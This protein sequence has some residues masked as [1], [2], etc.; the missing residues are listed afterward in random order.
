MAK[1]KVIVK[2]LIS[3]EDLGNMDVLCTDKTGTLTKG[4]LLF[5]EAQDL[6]GNS[7]QEVMLNALLTNDEFTSKGGR[8]TSSSIDQALWR[9]E[10]GEK[11]K[12]NLPK[13]TLIDK[14]EFSFENKRA[15]VLVTDG[16][17]RF[18]VSKGSIESILSICSNAFIRGRKQ[19]LDDKLRIGLRKRFE[20]YENFGYKVIAV[21]KKDEL[22]GNSIKE[23]DLTL[24]GIIL[25]EDP[26]KETA[27]DSI[28]QLISSGVRIV[29]LSGDDSKVVEKIAIE[30]GMDFGNIRV[31]SGE[32][33]EKMDENQFRDCVINCN[34]FSRLTPEEKY[35][36]VGVL[37]K[38]G[39]VVGFLGDG[40][41]DSPALKAADVGIAVDSGAVIAKEA[42]DIVLLSKDLNV[43]IDG[44]KLGRTTFA[45]I[46]KYILN[47]ISANFGNMS[48]VALSSIFLKFI[49][50]LPSQILLNNLIS[51]IPLLAIVSDSVDKNLLT[52]PKHWDIRL[53]G[54]FMIY[55][56]ILSSIFDMMLIL[57]MIIL[58]KVD[59]VVFR[60]AWFIESSISEIIITFSIRTKLIFFKSRPSLILL[61][62]SIFSILL[63]LVLP[64][65][66]LGKNFF[67][68]VPLPKQVWM[69]II[70]DLALY[71]VSCEIIKKE[72]F[73][74]FSN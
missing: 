3:V 49:P 73:K 63:V 24:L 42:A 2:K 28:A 31:V 23:I 36:I 1:K 32:D 55:F 68:F 17:H 59:P 27:K 51:D 56:G 21:A 71:F 44:I 34:L 41:N 64:F 37:N 65:I 7:S 61:I 10:L 46:T 33:L 19:K 45:N 22:L 26:I 35:K 4:E 39:K 74:R 57:G 6:D 50:L 53:I 54:K 58:L 48:T 40:I 16:N 14:N 66:G 18:Q 60:T 25:L 69:F 47:T 52:K 72:F 67:A 12:L 13:F 38:E 9:C 20:D 15:S 29:I 70:A 5:K 8:I 11:L 62:L 43:L 30:T